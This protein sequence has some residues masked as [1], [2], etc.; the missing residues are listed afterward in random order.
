MERLNGVNSKET[1]LNL[2]CRFPKKNGKAASKPKASSQVCH[3]VCVNENKWESILEI[4]NV[5]WKRTVLINKHFR[6]LWISTSREKAEKTA[7]W[8]KYFRS[9][10]GI[11][12][13]LINYRRREIQSHK[14]A[15]PSEKNC[16]LKWS[17]RVGVR[18]W[19]LRIMKLGEWC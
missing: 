11:F 16:F 18:R 10:K 13:Q 1:L 3:V 4:F 14:S 19:K 5:D 6:V 2:F 9:E 17:V 15:N 7:K 8:E 12:F